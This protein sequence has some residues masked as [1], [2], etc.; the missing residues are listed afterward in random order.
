[1]KITIP[2]LLAGSACA[3][4]LASA[5]LAAS[6]NRTQANN[7]TA[8]A[9]ARTAA[10]ASAAAPSTP[11][12]H[13]QHITNT[14][15]STVTR[16]VTVTSGYR[17]NSTAHQRGAIDISSKDL[18]PSARHGEAQQISKALGS[19]HTVVVEE[20]HRVPKGAHGPEAQI[21]PAYRDGQ[22]GNI[23]VGPIKAD[24]THT[25]IQPDAPKAKAPPAKKSLP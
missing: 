19:Q 8:S 20:V 12:Q 4:A 21:N 25:H 10:P 7:T 11:A 17:G 9:P 5:C 22:R 16:P 13:R 6:D 14:V 24:A 2:R 1:M 18:T 15:N 3:A 23:R